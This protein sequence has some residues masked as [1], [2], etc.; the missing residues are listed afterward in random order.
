MVNFQVIVITRR[1]IQHSSSCFWRNSRKLYGMGI[2]NNTF[3]NYVGCWIG[4]KL[5]ERWFIFLFNWSISIYFQQLYTGILFNMKCN[6]IYCLELVLVHIF[7]IF[8]RLQHNRAT[9]DEHPVVKQD[10]KYISA[11]LTITIWCTKRSYL[12][13]IFGGADDF[14]APFG[15]NNTPNF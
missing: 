14:V 13:I 8:N 10:P 9:C 7:L 12:R 5:D 3:N 2:Q 4:N 6:G 15:L 1:F 11:K